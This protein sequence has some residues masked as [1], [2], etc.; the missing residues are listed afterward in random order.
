[1]D[2][3]FFMAAS[4]QKPHGASVAIWFIVLFD[5]FGQM[6]TTGI[7]HTIHLLSHSGFKGRWR[8]RWDSSVSYRV[9][10]CLRWKQTQFPPSGH[11]LPYRLTCVTTIKSVLTAFW[12]L[13]WE[14][15]T[16]SNSSFLGQKKEC[17]GRKTKRLKTKSE[18]TNKK[19]TKTWLITSPWQFC[20][21]YDFKASIQLL[22]IPKIVVWML[23]D[24]KTEK[25]VF[26]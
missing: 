3:T 19:T 23:A 22:K 14:E 16:I 20:L 10:S 25:R 17:N 2:I 26:H 7:V 1:M 9:W 24:W 12:H 21:T 4:T 11:T 8:Q 13:E 15:D 5:L 6:A 18:K